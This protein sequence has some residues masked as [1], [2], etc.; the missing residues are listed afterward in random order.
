ML[1]FVFIL[2]PSN[3]LPENLHELSYSSPSDRRPNGILPVQPLSRKHRCKAMK[4][5]FRQIS[6]TAIGFQN[7]MPVQKSDKNS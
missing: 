6:C 3:D 2:Q 5:H 4:C 1:N 7:C